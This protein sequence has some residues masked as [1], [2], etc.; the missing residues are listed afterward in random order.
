ML[1]HLA[2]YAA[3]MASASSFCYSQCHHCYWHA[4]TCI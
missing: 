3:I 4:T 1:Y 2:S